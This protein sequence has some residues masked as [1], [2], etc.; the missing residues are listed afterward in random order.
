M[1]K[2]KQN[3]KKKAPEIKAAH[4]DTQTKKA[5]PKPRPEW[6]DSSNDMSQYKLSQTELVITP[7]IHKINPYFS[8]RSRKECL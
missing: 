4:S 8:H 3:S 1:L 7:D 2:I 5:A 6:N